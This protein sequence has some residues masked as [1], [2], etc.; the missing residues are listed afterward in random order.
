MCLNLVTPSLLL[1]F[2]VFLYVM[3]HLKHLPAILVHC[4]ISHTH[5]YPV[6]QFFPSQ[7]T[8]FPPLWNN[9]QAVIFMSPTSPSKLQIFFSVICHVYC[10][11]LFNNL[12]KT[13]YWILS[14]NWVLNFCV[15]LC[16]WWSFGTLFL[17]LFFPI[18]TV[19]LF[20][21]WFCLA[22]WF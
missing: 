19:D 18:N 21:A 9:L 17:T 13:F 3:Q 12:C 7:I 16:Y 15:C 6:L 10:S 4:V 11:I 22:W 2:S 1:N 8:F 20:I 14:L 5:A